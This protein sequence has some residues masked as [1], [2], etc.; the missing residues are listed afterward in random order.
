MREYFERNKR[1]II[2]TII[3]HLVVVLIILFLGFSTQLPLPGE[4]G[5]IIT[6][7]TDEAGFG[8]TQPQRQNAA[9]PPPAPR[10]VTVPETEE[11]IMTQDIDE[12]PALPTP[13]REEPK[14]PEPPR[15]VA[16]PQPAPVPEPAPEEVAEVP[17]RRPNPNALF[18]GRT[19]TGE[20]GSTQGETTG[21]GNQGRET[22][23]PDSPHRTG[24]DSGSPDGISFSLAGRNPLSL[25]LP[26][27]NYQVEGVVV[28]EVTVNRNG[29]VI[30]AIPG[31]RGSTTLNNYLLTTARRAAE[32]ARFNVKPDAPASQKGTITYVFRLE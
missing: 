25:P 20:A 10:P 21:P 1:G 18:P 32:R 11:Q 29:D 4:E 24:G 12:A 14:K 27:Y 2:G 23:S 28:V 30:N 7:G 6:F 31:V 5:I 3:F 13:Q 26:D 8:F 22:G 15:P 16:E 17:E 19:A 9:P